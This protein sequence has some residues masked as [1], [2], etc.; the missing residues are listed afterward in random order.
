MAGHDGV[1]IIFDQSAVDHA[2]G[3]VPL[4][5]REGVHVVGQVGIPEIQAVA[6]EVLGGAGKARHRVGALEVGGAHLGYPVGIVAEG[7]GDDL[8]VFPVVVD[9]ADRGESHV[10]A[11]GRGLLVGHAAQ[12]AGVLH[13]AGGAD[14]DAGADVGAVGTGAVAARLGVAGDEQGHFGVLLQS[15]VH[16]LDR[17]AGGGVI[18]AAAQMVFF[19]QL[20]QVV[21]LP[22]SGQLEKQLAHL[23]L[24]GHAGDGVFH[25]GDVLVGQ[26]IGPC[27][28]I[29]HNIRSFW[30]GVPAILC[31]GV[32]GTNQSIQI[33]CIIFGPDQTECQ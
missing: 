33:Y 19:H 16:G 2:V 13:L 28:E 7:P 30:A 24:V 15:A 25:P 10:A 6:G 5:H 9:V 1:Q 27:L 11:D 4:L 23:F 18:P 17:R 26:I 31:P 21:F 12:I 22:G 32:A 29:N 3:G 20:F 14:L 8:G